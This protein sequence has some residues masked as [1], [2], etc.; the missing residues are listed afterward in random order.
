VGEH[1]QF[2]RGAGVAGEGAG[3]GGGG[4]E[5]EGGRGGGGLATGAGT[6]ARTGDGVEL[7]AAVGASG[8]QSTQE[9]P[10]KD[11]DGLDVGHPA[12][13]PTVM[14]YHA[15]SLNLRGL[16]TPWLSTWRLTASQKGTATVELLGRVAQEQ[17]KYVSRDRCAL[18]YHALARPLSHKGAACD[19]ALQQLV[20]LPSTM[21]LA[22]NA[23]CE[24]GPTPAICTRWH[25]GRIIGIMVKW[26]D[27]AIARL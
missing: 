9:D 25:E 26:H 7:G 13:P 17:T 24:G 10:R 21:L 19:A 14:Q 11:P 8:P 20:F 22:A 4:G 12:A 1:S 6:G 16:R 15:M 27:F 2:G 18:H 3:W 5:G 23:A